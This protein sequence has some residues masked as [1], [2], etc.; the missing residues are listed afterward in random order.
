MYAVAA[1]EQREALPLPRPGPR[2]PSAAP[3]A[4]PVGIRHAVAAAFVGDPRP[5]TLC[6]AGIDGWFV[7]SAVMFETSHAAACQRCA[8]LV[9]AATNSIQNRAGRTLTH[10]KQAQ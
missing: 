9:A 1:A 6:G 5:A 3:Q 7:F 4:Q 10:S 8:Q 2:R